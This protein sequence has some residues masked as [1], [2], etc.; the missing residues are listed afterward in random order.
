MNAPVVSNLE[1]VF[2]CNGQFYP[3]PG[4]SLT[5][6]QVR[7]ALAP[8]VPSVLNATVEGPA[9]DGNRAVYRFVTK[10]GTKG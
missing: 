10:L 2:E 3:D 1:R 9:I 8:S 6:E 7:V 4:A 5:L